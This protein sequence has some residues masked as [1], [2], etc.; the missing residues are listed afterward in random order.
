MLHFDTLTPAQYSLLHNSFWDAEG[1]GSEY[2]FSNLFFW[3]DQRLC[4]QFDRP[5]IL[6][7]FGDWSAYLYPR[8]TDFLEDIAE[9]AKQRGVPFRF[10][11]LTRK[12]ADELEARFPGRF[13]IRPMR[14]SF[15]YV[16]DIARLCELK[17]KKLQAKRNHCNRFLQDHPDYRVVPLTPEL[18]PLCR[19]FTE[20]W[21]RS[22]A[23]QNLDGDYEKEKIAISRAFDH[24][25]TLRFHGIMLWDGDQ[26]MGFSM[27]NQIREDTFDVNFEKALPHV[28]GAYPM[29]NRE[30]ARHIHAHFPAIRFLNRED[31]MGIE[32]LRRAKESYY[33]DILLEKYL[34]EEASC[35]T[36][37][38]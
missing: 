20:Q 38:L 13:C 21:Y 9:D 15:D 31:D 19:Q 35:S 33:P 6:S 23:E 37:E 4:S 24:F 16:Y 18:L 22:H 32:G 27:G 25:T 2:S 14:N 5:L 36:D 7:R 12:E 29:V 28:N 34:A 8:T 3:G 11:G 26:L 10:W 1:H 30:F 17:G